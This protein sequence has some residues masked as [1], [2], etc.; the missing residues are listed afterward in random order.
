MI[1]KRSEIAGILCK[2][3][4]EPVVFDI[5]HLSKRGLRI[6][7]DPETHFPHRCDHVKPK[8]YR[9]NYCNEEIFF[10]PNIFNAANGKLIPQDTFGNHR[11]R[12]TNK[13]MGK[14]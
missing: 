11:N 13:K 14:L 2:Y 3:Y 7:L 6:P 12:C 8:F 9:C 4:N 1:S 5:E 10:D